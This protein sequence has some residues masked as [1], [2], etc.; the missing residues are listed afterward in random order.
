M[1]LMSAVFLYRILGDSCPNQILI[2]YSLAQESLSKMISVVYFDLLRPEEL[3]EFTR[4][5]PELQEPVSRVKL[6]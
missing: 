6:K 1:A 3:L 4:C 2:T 5:G